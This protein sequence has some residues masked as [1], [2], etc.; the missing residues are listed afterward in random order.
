[1]RSTPAN[2]SNFNFNL[3]VE[4]NGRANDACRSLYWRSTAQTP[5]GASIDGEPSGHKSLPG[6]ETQETSGGSRRPARLRDIIAP[7]SFRK[8]Q[9][10][11]DERRYAPTSVPFRRNPCSRSPGTLFHFT[12]IPS[13]NF[14]SHVR[15]HSALGGRTPAEAYGE[16]RAA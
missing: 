7:K 13:R 14:Y 3:P 8:V 11:T 4:S 2:H 1:M 12:G 9:G 15:P 10:L 6:F 16:E 5:H